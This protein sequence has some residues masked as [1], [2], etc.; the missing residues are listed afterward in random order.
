MSGQSGQRSSVQERRAEAGVAA[1][2]SPRPIFNLGED[3]EG[4][5][6]AERFTWC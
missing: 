4:R 5:A 1:S 6:A 3:E 2:H